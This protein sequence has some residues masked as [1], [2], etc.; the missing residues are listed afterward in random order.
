MKLLVCASLVF[1]GVTSPA[2]AADD[3][4]VCMDAAELEASLIEWHNETLASWDGSDTY[5]WASG[6]GGS[7]TIVQYIG[8]ESDMIACVI[9]Q[10]IDW[11]PKLHEDILLA[12]AD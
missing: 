10:G 11:T 6:V 7:W 8:S 3:E 1:I 5:V 9:D 4:T 12:T 2:S